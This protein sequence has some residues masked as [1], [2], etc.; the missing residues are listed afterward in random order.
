[1]TSLAFA[2]AGRITV[3]H[4]LAARAVDGLAVTRVAS[5]SPATAQE[6][7]GQVGATACRYE[8][9]PAGADVVLVATPPARHAADALQAIGAGAKVIVEK[10]LATTLAQADALVEASA[11]AGHALGYAENLAFAPIVVAAVALAGELGPLRHVEVSALQGRPDWGGFL[12]A[13]WGGGALFDLGVHPIAVALLLARA[14]DGGR[15]DGGGRVVS[16]RADLRGADDIEV[17]EQA[18]MWITFASGLVATVEAS[19]AS[20][21]QVWDLQAAGDTGVVRAELVPHLLLERDGEPVALPPLPAGADIP[22]IHQ[23]GYVAQLEDLLRDFAHG[24]EPVMSAAFGRE[25]LELV[26]AAYASA[27]RGGQEVPLPFDGPR[28]RTPLELWLDAR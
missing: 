2:G 18:R 16:V 24:R 3:V 9:L 10:P 15:P 27:G 1:M 21:Q 20:D 25:V 12:E 5:R 11:G 8:D 23:F 4:G 7:A 6:R 14:H 22:Q 17:D 13:A 28:D 19:W 26:C